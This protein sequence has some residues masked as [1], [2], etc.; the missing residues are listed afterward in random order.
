M[1][2]TYWKNADVWVCCNHMPPLKLPR[3]VPR[4]WVSTCNAERPAMSRAH[5]SV[6]PSETPMALPVEDDLCEWE[7][8]TRGENRGRGIKAE[9]KH[10]KRKYCSHECRKAK[11]RKKYSDKK[12]MEKLKLNLAG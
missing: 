2:K 11:A 3:I 1:K 12:K 9:G 5:L 6:V 8:C 4:C 7:Y 10:G